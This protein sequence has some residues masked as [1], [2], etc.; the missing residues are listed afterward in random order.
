MAADGASL[1]DA[2]RQALKEEIARKRLALTVDESRAGVEVTEGRDLIT[3]RRFL[4]LNE[5]LLAKGALE[6]SGI[7][8]FLFDENVARIYWSNLLGGIKLTVNREDAEAATS[9]LDEARPE[10]TDVESVDSEPQ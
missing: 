10:T 8:C 5:A 2:A 6:S 1:T 9:I 7:E 3:V 4:G